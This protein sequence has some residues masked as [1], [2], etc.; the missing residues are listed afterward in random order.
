MEENSGIYVTE[1]FILSYNKA[2]ESVQLL[3]RLPASSTA[4]QPTTKRAACRLDD[5]RYD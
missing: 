2:L 3:G 4:A 1:K 5:Q